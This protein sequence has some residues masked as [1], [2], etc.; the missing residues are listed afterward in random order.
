MEAPSGGAE[1]RRWARGAS[2]VATMEA[3]SGGAGLE[4]HAGGVQKARQKVSGDSGGS[5]GWRRPRAR[6]SC[7]V[8]VPGARRPLMT[9]FSAFP[10]YS[11]VPLFAPASRFRTEAPPILMCWPRSRTRPPPGARRPPG[12][13]RDPTERAS[14]PVVTPTGCGSIMSPSKAW[15]SRAQLAAEVSGGTR[16]PP[17]RRQPPLGCL[18]SYPRA[19][20][21]SPGPVW[22]R[23]QRPPAGVEPSR[24][25]A[26][27]QH[28]AEIPRSN[29]E[30][31]MRIQ[32]LTRDLS[33]FPL[34][35]GTRGGRDRPVVTGQRP[36]LTGAPAAGA[37][38]PARRAPRPDRTGVSAGR[39]ARSVGFP[40]PSRHAGRR[41]LPV[42]TR[43]PVQGRRGLGGDMFDRANAHVGAGGDA[44]LEG[45][46]SAMWWISVRV[47]MSITR[48]SPVRTRLLTE[49]FQGLQTRRAGGAAPEAPRRRRLRP[50]D[51]RGAAPGRPSGP[52]PRGTDRA[53]LPRAR[54]APAPS[55]GAPSSGARL[56]VV[57][58]T[59]T[60][61][62]TTRV[63]D[64]LS[65]SPDAGDVECPSDGAFSGIWRPSRPGDFGGSRAPS[66]SHV[67]PV[68]GRRE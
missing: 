50:G 60:S 24:T 58:C 53:A 22:A 3:P 59:P 47:M 64:V 4:V 68:S 31:W 40:P 67:C 23:R 62:A 48:R 18:P 20:N 43:R 63:T 61:S 54:R 30:W 21:G 57:A 66:V 1:W 14:V 29:S 33:G 19:P 56:A 65:S 17:T 55:G 13:P 45:P 41:D 27:E 51:R 35:L 12:R 36:V 8:A 32:W 52:A 7:R 49:D 34:P 5:S 16:R 25:A 37:A 2:R 6:A 15:K 46:P 39:D 28:F 38:P 26:P 42:V 10:D 44:G 11:S 9:A